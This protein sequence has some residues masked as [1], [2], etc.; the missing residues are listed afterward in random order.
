MGCVDF[1]SESLE[2]RYQT[3]GKILIE[4]D[5]YRIVGA[6]RTGKSSSADAAAKAIAA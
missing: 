4:L 5:P 6:D 2:K 3:K 1:V